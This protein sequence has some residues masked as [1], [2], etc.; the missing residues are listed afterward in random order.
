MS[1]CHEHGI[2]HSK[3]LSWSAEDR[4]KAL[5]YT[6][7][8]ATRCTMCGT[9]QWEWDEDKFAYTA[10]EDFCKGCYQKQVAQEETANSLPGTSIRLVPTTQQLKDEMFLQAQRR[11]RMMREE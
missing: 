10:I 4:S 7:E 8:K 11:G 6:L 1:Y 2:P 3:F 9:A 5:A